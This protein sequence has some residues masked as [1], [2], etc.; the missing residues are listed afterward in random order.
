MEVRA[1]DICQNWKKPSQSLLILTLTSFHTFSNDRRNQKEK[2]VSSPRL[3]Y[4]T[5]V[6]L[7]YLSLSE[8][9]YDCD[10]R[11]S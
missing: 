4:E 1:V 8:V 10:S 7:F 5:L 11:V 9:S 3:T 6:G 2:V